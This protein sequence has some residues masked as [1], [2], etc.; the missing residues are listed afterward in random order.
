[1]HAAGERG[2]NPAVIDDEALAAEALEQ[3]LID[4]L[5]A[6]QAA[7][8]RASTRRLLGLKPLHKGRLREALSRLTAAM[9]TASAAAVDT[10]AMTSALTTATQAR[11]E[12]CGRL[13]V[14][15]ALGTGYSLHD[16][17][18]VGTVRGLR[19]ACKTAVDLKHA[20]YT[21]EQIRAAGVVQGLREAGYS[22]AEV[23][24]RRAH[25]S[26]SCHS[27]TTHHCTRVCTLDT[28]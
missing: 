22:C 12:A 20:G 17:C 27:L 1:M 10:A 9:D 24:T 3:Q 18:A 5:V 26:H 11:R 6:S 19:A 7:L 4:E 8:T 14:R 13:T 21:L 16:L 28:D 23:R 2:E 15:E 25:S